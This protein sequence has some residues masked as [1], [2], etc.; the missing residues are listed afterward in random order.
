MDRRQSNLVTQLDRLFLYANRI[1]LALDSD[2]Q[3]VRKSALSDIAEAGEI[4]RRLYS[5]LKTQLLGS[6]EDS[7]DASSQN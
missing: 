7:V 6:R 3:L 1:K 5:M 2:N 4:S